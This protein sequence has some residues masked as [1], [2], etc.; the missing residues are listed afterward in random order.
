MKKNKKIYRANINH[1]YF[2]DIHRLLL[3]YVGIYEIIDNV[4]NRFGELEKAYIIN[5]F[6]QGSPENNIDLIFL[7]NNFDHKFSHKLVRTAEENISFKI[8]YITVSE[9][10]SSNYIPDLAKAL[11]VRSSE[12]I[13]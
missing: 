12:K 13:T 11:L 6:A 10:E 3:N 1:P 7:G 5:D 8:K 2:N 4:V 9:D